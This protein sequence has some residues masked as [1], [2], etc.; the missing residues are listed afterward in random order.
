MTNKKFSDLTAATT[1]SGTDLLAIVQGGVSKKIAASDFSSVFTVAATTATQGIAQLA[2]NAETV[3]GTN[4]T[5]IVTP[6]DLQYSAATQ[7]FPSIYMKS[8]TGGAPSA[9]GINATQYLVN[10][11]ALPATIQATPVAMLASTTC[12]VVVD[13]TTYASY[14]IIFNRV[15]GVGGITIDASSNGGSGYTGFSLTGFQVATTTVTSISSVPAG[16]GTAS[17]EFTFSQA[18]TGGNIQVTASGGTSPSVSFII[19][20]SSALSAAVN[21]IKFTASSF[22]ATGY[23][24]LIPLARR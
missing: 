17:C 11:V 14:K 15:T 21:R 2:T 20:G 6:D 1:F 12:I 24:T 8:A 19:S 4:T 10:G 9:G 7:G 23:Y 22:A 5:K 18:T 16:D 13:F 3:T